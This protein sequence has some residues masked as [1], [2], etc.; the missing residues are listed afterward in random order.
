MPD[1]QLQALGAHHR[2]LLRAARQISRLPGVRR[3]AVMPDAQAGAGGGVVCNGIAVG[4]DD[5]IYPLLV[6]K[7]I[8]CGY[9][10]LTF[11]GDTTVLTHAARKELL[12]MLAGPWPRAPEPWAS[13]EL[14]ASQLNRAFQ[15]DGQLQLGTLGRGNHFL[16][17][18]RDD[19][20]TLSALVHSG[21]RSMGPRICA[22]HHARGT[23]VRHGLNALEPEKSQGV[24][25]LHDL[26]WARSYAREN[27]RRILRIVEQLLLPLGFE[28]EWDVWIDRDHNRLDREVV[29]TEPMWIQRKSVNRARRDEVTVVAGTMA[30]P[31]YVV[32]GRGDE[33]FLNSCAHGAG[34]VLSRGAGRDRVDVD[35]L[36]D[37][38]RGITFD[39][40]RSI[41][42]APQ[43]YR[44]PESVIRDQRKLAKPVLKLT[45]VLNFRSG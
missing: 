34:R 30:G 23:P 43:V 11:S 9:S 38:M 24:D 31:T 29:D 32:Q 35:R 42:E 5:L 13:G 33:R 20:G 26:A 6:G 7:D 4:S 1:A 37:V 14:S 25:Y 8:G 44:D 17:L 18:L 16:E 39:P 27:R 10:L 12:R 21:S 45:P 15:R 19:T 2:E 36:H 3:V 28:A 41:S 22:Y 40:K